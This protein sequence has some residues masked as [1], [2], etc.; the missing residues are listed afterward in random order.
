MLLLAG[1]TCTAGEGDGCD[2]LAEGNELILKLQKKSRENRAKNEREL[3]EL[4]NAKL[5][6][7]EYLMTNGKNLVLKEDGKCAA[8]KEAECVRG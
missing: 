4:T 1:Q 7:D 6:Y 2:A 5:G 3:F 8:L